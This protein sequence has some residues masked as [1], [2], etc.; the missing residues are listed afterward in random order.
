MRPTLLSS[1]TG[2]AL[3]L[4]LLVS[5]PRALAAD[6]F[7]FDRF[8]ELARK[9]VQGGTVTSVERET[10]K[11]KRAVVEVEI[12]APDGNE[13]ELVFDEADGKLLSHRVDD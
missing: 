1:L 9:E 11:R 13:H 2:A 6:T 10:K 3:S 5:A 4:G 8:A 12:D 7:S